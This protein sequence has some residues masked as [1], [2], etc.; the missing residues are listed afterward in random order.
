MVQN[1]YSKNQNKIKITFKLF[2]FKPLKNN[3][4][5]I[6]LILKLEKYLN[7]NYVKTKNDFLLLKIV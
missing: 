7:G 4:K 1:N 5:R 3:V 2:R 6:K